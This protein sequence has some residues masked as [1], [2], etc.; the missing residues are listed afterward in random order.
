MFRWTS[1][2]VE[3]GLTECYFFPSP[4]SPLLPSPLLPSPLL[5]PLPSPLL[6]SPFPTSPF[7]TSP[8]GYFMLPTV[9]TGVKDDSRLMHEEIFGENQLCSSRPL[10][11]APE[12]QLCCARS[13]HSSVLS[14]MQYT[15]YFS[16]VAHLFLL[17]FIYPH[18]SSPFL[19][20]PSPHS[21]SPLLPLPSPPPC[22]PEGPVVCI[23]PFK[24]EEEVIC[25][26]NNTV[27]GLAASVW[28]QDVGRLTRV[29]QALKVRGCGRLTR[30][31][32][33]LKV[34]GCGRLSLLHL[35]ACSFWS[36]VRLMRRTFVGLVGLK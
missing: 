35:S 23:V 13:F 24:T 1:C 33:A 3:Y 6:P 14:H 7:P 21:P 18:L 27:Y 5:P 20:S 30:V 34:R 22:L 15:L 16:L 32:Q 10:P 36:D 4:P 19:L 28:G 12:N 31:A 25:R 2:R 8:Q 9:I 26:A 29:A 17:C 11:C